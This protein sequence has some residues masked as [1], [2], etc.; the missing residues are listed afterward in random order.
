MVRAVFHPLAVPM[1]EED[2]FIALG[3]KGGGE[4][5]GVSGGPFVVPSHVT[6]KLKS[7]PLKLLMEILG[8]YFPF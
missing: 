4:L 5:D 1:F 2:Q 6:S 8:L 7:Q 3:V